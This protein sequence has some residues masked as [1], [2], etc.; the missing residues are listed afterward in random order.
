MNA[1]PESVRHALKRYI[2]ENYLQEEDAD[3][4]KNDTPLIEDGILDS[5]SIFQLVGF[6]KEE[7]GVK[8]EAHEIANHMNTIEEITGIVVERTQAS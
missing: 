4:L 2:L 6:V 1:S 7:Y 5:I 3:D 8:L